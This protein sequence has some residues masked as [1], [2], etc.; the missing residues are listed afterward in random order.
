MNQHVPHITTNHVCRNCLCARR[1]KLD[2]LKRYLVECLSAI[3]R[4][5]TLG[6]RR[7]VW[8]EDTSWCP[9]FEEAA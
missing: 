5:D 2:K 1:T 8:M 9:Y 3:L 4:M 6:D 7:G